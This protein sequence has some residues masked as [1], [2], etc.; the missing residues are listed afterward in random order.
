VLLE[1]FTEKESELLALLQSGF[2]VEILA[3]E[4]MISVNTVRF[5]LRNRYAKIGAVNRT[6][7]VSFA[8]H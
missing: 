7:A 8:R 1:P 2:P 6:Q 5:H 3:E 4:L